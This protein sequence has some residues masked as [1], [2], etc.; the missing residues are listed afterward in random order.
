[1]SRKGFILVLILGVGVKGAHGELSG[2]HLLPYVVTLGLGALYILFTSYWSVRQRKE[3]HTEPNP[4]QTEVTEPIQTE[5]NQTEPSQTKLDSVCPSSPRQTE[6]EVDDGRNTQEPPIEAATV[7]QSATPPTATPTQSA[8]PPTATPATATP[9][10]AETTTPSPSPRPSDTAERKSLSTRPTS[11]PPEGYMTASEVRHVQELLKR[12]ELKF[13]EKLLRVELAAGE[14]EKKLQ[15]TMKDEQKEMATLGSSVA[16]LTQ[17]RDALLKMVSQYKGMLATLVTEKEKEKKMS[18]E[19]I[20]ALQGERDQALE[21]LANVEVAFSDVHRRHKHGRQVGR[22]KVVSTEHGVWVWLRIAE[23]IRHEAPPMLHHRPNFIHK[24]IF[25][26]IFTVTFTTIITCIIAR[27]VLKVGVRRLSVTY[28][29]KKN[30][31][32][33]KIHSCILQANMAT[34]NVDLLRMSA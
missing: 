11:A 10:A 19:K 28:G 14:K 26:L 30:K 22:I 21:D 33:K 8:T 12:Q 7:T 32:E 29:S 9:P 27:K 34:E 20:S 4:T 23:Q 6:V 31:K 15:Q 13:E 25:T 17:S 2:G 1:M 3:D 24:I 18:D 5:I 16:E